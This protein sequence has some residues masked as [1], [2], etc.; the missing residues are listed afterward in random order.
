MIQWLYEWFINLAFGEVSISL[1]GLYHY[2]MESD[3]NKNAGKALATDDEVSGDEK[4]GGRFYSHSRQGSATDEKDEESGNIELGPQCS[5]RDQLEKDK[6]ASSF[7]SL[8]S[9]F[10]LL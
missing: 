2:K 5:L 6:V 1:R 10:P 9:F 8:L 3:E 7:S 4:A